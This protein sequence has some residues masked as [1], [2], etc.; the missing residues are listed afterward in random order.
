MQ[1]PIKGVPLGARFSSRDALYSA[2]MH[3]DVQRDI[4]GGSAAG[5]GAESVVES[6]LVMDDIDIGRTVYFTGL[7][8]LGRA[9]GQLSDQSFSGLNGLLALNVE[10]GASI[11]LIVAVD[12][13][14]EYRG[15]YRVLDAWS[16][17]G[18]NGWTICR[19]RFERNVNPEIENKFAKAHAIPDRRLTVHFAMVRDAGVP[20]TV[21]KLYDYRCQICGIRLETLG[22]PY[23]EGA[24]LIPLGGS[25]GGGIDDV[26]NV[27]CLCPNHHVLL[28]HGAIAFSDNWSV[29]DRAGHDLGQLYVHPKHGLNIA[30]AKVHREAMG[31]LPP[32][33]TPT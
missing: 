6:G 15:L 22:G 13:E 21:K 3:R 18:Q 26:T 4:C 10:S 28:D 29:Y 1:G 27:L 5:T 8:G 30:H 20:A 12:G 23:A 2:G 25:N 16:T 32:S 31:I 19:Y 33:S 9:G 17:I 11:R 14:F 7:G 24:H